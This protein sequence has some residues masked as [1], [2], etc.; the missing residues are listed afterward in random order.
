MHNELIAVDAF[1]VASTSKA[2][3]A[4]AYYA[5]AFVDAVV[6]HHHHQWVAFDVVVAAVVD[7]HSI[8]A[9]ATYDWA[10]AAAA[11]VHPFHILVVVVVAVAS[12]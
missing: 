3:A 2:V 8:N 9:V 11:F 4:V 12:S 5:L 10:A 6:V 1:V 7:V